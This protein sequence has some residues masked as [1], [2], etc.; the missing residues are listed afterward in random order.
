MPICSML[1][2]L[3][4]KATSALQLT[5]VEG[6]NSEEWMLRGERIVAGLSLMH[7]VDACTLRRKSQ[8]WANMAASSKISATIKHWY[9]MQEQIPVRGQVPP[10]NLERCTSLAGLPRQPMKRLA[11]SAWALSPECSGSPECWCARCEGW[12]AGMV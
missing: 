12:R 1:D 3:V 6:S 7:I 11:P 9:Q 5:Q 2:R 10:V 8:D 4:K